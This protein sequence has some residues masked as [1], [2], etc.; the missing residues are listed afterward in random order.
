MPNTTSPSD[1]RF[2]VALS[3]PGEKRDFV[4]EVAD[5]LSSALG[6]ARVFYDGFYEAELS[7]AY[8]ERFSKRMSRTIFFNFFQKK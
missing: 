3:Y 5:H 2:L 4:K 6:Q 7:R 1:R 8:L